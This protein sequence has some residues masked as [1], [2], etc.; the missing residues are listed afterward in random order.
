M[1]ANY[2][3]CTLPLFLSCAL[4]KV[5]PVAPPIIPPTTAPPPRFFLLTIAPSAAPLTTPMAVPFAASLIPC[6]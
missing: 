4:P 6:F 1:Y 5:Y 2:F 3:G